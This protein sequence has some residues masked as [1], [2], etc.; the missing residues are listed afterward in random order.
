MQRYYDIVA[1]E[2]KS[3]QLVDGLWARA[4]AETGDEDSRARARYIK[5][6]AEQLQLQDEWKTREDSRRR[7]M[8]GDTQREAELRRAYEAEDREILRRSKEEPVFTRVILIL[9][10]IFIAGSLIFFVVLLFR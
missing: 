5:L 7:K 4:V 9:S 10:A 1:S 2:L 3:R 8:E 6:R